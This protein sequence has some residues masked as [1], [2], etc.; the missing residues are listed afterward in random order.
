MQNRTV[1]VVEDD[2]EVLYMLSRALAVGG[3]DVVWARSAEHA[4]QLLNRH[5]QKIALLLTDVV[6]PGLSGAALVDQAVQVYPQMRV[7]YVSAFDRDTVVS[8]G[9]DPARDPFLAKP[10]DP[11]ELSLGVKQILKESDGLATAPA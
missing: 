1:M 2:Q 7:L 9:V 6:L 4:L 8:H 3:F 11:S 10:C 5:Q